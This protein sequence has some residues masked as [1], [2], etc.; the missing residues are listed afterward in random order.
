MDETSWKPIETTPDDDRSVLVYVPG[1]HKEVFEA[2]A[3]KTGRY[4]DPV[5]NEWDGDGA[6]H[7]MPL[8]KAPALSQATGNKESGADDQ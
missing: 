5:Y 3:T 4:Y 7:W 2:L 1:S 8:P 6:T